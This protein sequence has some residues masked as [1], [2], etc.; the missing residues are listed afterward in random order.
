MYLHTMTL[1]CGLPS[2]AAGTKG[3]LARTRKSLINP[4][5]KSIK[6]M[7]RIPISVGLVKT[8][9]E[10]INPAALA[11]NVGTTPKG[12]SCRLCSS[13]KDNKP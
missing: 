2:S 11:S 10:Q 5:E 4:T 6:C 9:Q 12:A 13:Q 3:L 8:V 1:F 7:P